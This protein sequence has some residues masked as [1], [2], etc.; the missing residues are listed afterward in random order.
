MM[1][2]VLYRTI[3]ELTE[4]TQRQAETIKR[5]TAALAQLGATIE[6]ERNDSK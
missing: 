2:E 5:Q 4:L 6:E 1:T 3:E